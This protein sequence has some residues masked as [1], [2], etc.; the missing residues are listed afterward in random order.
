MFSLSKIENN[1]LV[2]SSFSLFEYSFNHLSV[3]SLNLILELLRLSSINLS[4]STSHV[5]RSCAS[6]PF[7]DDFI[8]LSLLGWLSIR[9]T[10][11]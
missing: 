3:I 10:I 5:K 4:S 7:L 2:N 11:L 6:I 1:S 8:T 9:P